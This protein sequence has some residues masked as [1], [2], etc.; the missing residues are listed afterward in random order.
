MHE[1]STVSCRWSRYPVEMIEDDDGGGGDNDKV[2]TTMIAE[3]SNELLTETAR[4]GEED[5]T[6]VVWGDDGGSD[7]R[8]GGWCVCGVWCVVVNGVDEKKS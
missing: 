3:R 5:A 6:L 1:V 2:S 8:H 7:G 4:V